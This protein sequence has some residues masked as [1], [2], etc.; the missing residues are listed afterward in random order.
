MVKTFQ[1]CCGQDQIRHHHSVS[2]LLLNTHNVQGMALRAGVCVVPEG[3]FQED[4]AQAS[5]AFPPPSVYLWK[6]SP[7]SLNLASG[8]LQARKQKNIFLEQHCYRRSSDP[9]A[10][11]Q[12]FLW[13]KIC[14]KYNGDSTTEPN[15][16]CVAICLWGKMH[17]RLQFRHQ[18][19]FPLYV[20]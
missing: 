7:S 5:R 14:L 18:G 15:R 3:G 13:P 19:S 12:H 2:S 6:S 1:N 4:T 11:P 20:A 17:S 16:Y 8:S 10:N 9:Q